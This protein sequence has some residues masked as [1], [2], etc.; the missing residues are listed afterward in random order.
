MK[1]TEFCPHCE[2]L[3]TVSCVEREVKVSVRGEEFP[4]PSIV[5]VCSECGE[6]FACSADSLDPVDAA[7]SLYREKHGMLSPSE[8]LGFRRRYE[9]TQKELSALL[10]WGAVTLSRYENGA[11]QDAAHDRQLHAVMTGEGLKKLIQLNPD[12]LD[13]V[14]RERILEILD[15]RRG[16][17][18]GLLGSLEDRL[19]EMP[20][21]AM[22][23]FRR[24]SAGRFSAVVESFLRDGAVFKTK[25]NKLLFYADF[26]HFRDFGVSITGCRYAKLQYGPVPDDFKTLLGVLEEEAGVLMTELVDFPDKDYKGEPITLLNSLN[27]YCLSPDEERTVRRIID[28]FR[29]CGAREIAEFSHCFPG[30]IET[31]PSR[32][33][34]YDYA[35]SLELPETS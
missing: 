33:I 30:W 7:F 5:H 15:C 35:D 13:S 26:L 16:S 23:G 1:R 28:A 12:A 19:S 21:C 31:A 34:S 18:N 17:R 24:F 6:E 10:G 4:V 11:L 9:L 14:K 32:L 2:E 8:I 20:P 3:R 27:E 29:G 25:L 22:N